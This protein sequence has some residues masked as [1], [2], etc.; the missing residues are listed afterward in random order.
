MAKDR[1]FM[2]PVTMSFIAS[3][4]HVICMYIALVILSFPTPITYPPRMPKKSAYIVRIGTITSMASNLGTTRYCTGFADIVSSA[5]T[6]SV[7]FMVPSSALIDAPH[8]PATIRA[9]KTGPSSRVSESDTSE[10]MYIS[11]ETFCIWYALWRAST[12][13]V[14]KLMRSTIGKLATPILFICSSTCHFLILGA[15]IQKT[16]W[17]RSTVSPPM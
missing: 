13:P 9:V 16:D 8:L 6:C 11:A 14:K 4:S 5:S 12:M 17:P 1:L 7:T 2:S 10:A 15:N 3:G